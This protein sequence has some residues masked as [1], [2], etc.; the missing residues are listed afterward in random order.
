MI[1]KLKQLKKQLPKQDYLLVLE[2]MQEKLM[3]KPSGTKS[4]AQKQK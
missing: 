1:T 4:Q 2:K 3:K